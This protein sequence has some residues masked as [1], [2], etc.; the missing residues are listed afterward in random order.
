MQHK[1]QAMGIED[2]DG[3]HLVVQELGRRPLVAAE[4]EVHILGGEGVPVVEL[5]ALPQRKF[6]HQP[7]RA[8]RPGFCQAGGQGTAREGFDERVMKGIE[9]HK[10]GG[11]PGG[12]GRIEIGGS[13]GGV[14]GNHELSLG[15]ALRGRIYAQERCHHPR[16]DP[17]EHMS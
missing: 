17:N 4:A 11:E 7:I 8:L 12:L 15:F 6:V 9:K 5:H 13:N 1:A 16:D 14:E 10:G 2:L 3:L